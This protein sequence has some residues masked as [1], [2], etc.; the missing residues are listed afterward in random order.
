MRIISFQYLSEKNEGFI[1]LLISTEKRWVLKNDNI[2][3]WEEYGKV[4][5]QQEDKSLPAFHIKMA[6]VKFSYAISVS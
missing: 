6:D 3:F 1:F 5:E 2:A 4:L